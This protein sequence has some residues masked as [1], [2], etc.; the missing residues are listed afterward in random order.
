[1]Q[2]SGRDAADDVSTLAWGCVIQGGNKES[3][4]KA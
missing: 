4:R 3:P 1:M 2:Q